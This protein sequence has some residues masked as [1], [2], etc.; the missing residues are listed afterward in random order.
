MLK[1]SCYISSG[2]G[3]FIS[4]TGAG[5]SGRYL[6][7]LDGYVLIERSEKWI[8]RETYIQPAMAKE[9]VVRI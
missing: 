8:Q 9:L 2:Q 4:I 7:M 1:S 6:R 5:A 3:I